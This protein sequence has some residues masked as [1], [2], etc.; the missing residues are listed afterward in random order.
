MV[1]GLNKV[2]I[3]FFFELCVHSHFLLRIFKI[4]SQ[5]EWELLQMTVHIPT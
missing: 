5:T 2:K 1:L 3:L 4:A